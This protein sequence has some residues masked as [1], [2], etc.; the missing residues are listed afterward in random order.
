MPNPETETVAELVG[1]LKAGTACSGTHSTCDDVDA[2]DALMEQAASALTALQ[3]DKASMETALKLK[4]DEIEDLKVFL[5]KADE[6]V[7][8]LRA[9]RDA[10]V[11]ALTQAEVEAETAHGYPTDLSV[12]IG[13]FRREA[14]E[15]ASRSR[16]ELE[17]SDNG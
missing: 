16:S 15:K 13:Q 6:Q 5:A 10:Y 17:A 7:G 3:A 14:K 2:A 12:K 1:R 11:Q 8:R 4:A 9:E